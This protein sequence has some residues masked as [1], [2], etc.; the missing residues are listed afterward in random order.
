MAEIVY[1]N[2]ESQHNKHWSYN[3]T[4]TEIHIKWGR[5][6]GSSSERN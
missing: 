2:N 1:I 6:G 4:G 5:I 3:I